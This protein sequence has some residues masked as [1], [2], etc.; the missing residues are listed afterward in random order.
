MESG[1]VEGKEEKEEV[2]VQMGR[3]EGEEEAW[4]GDVAETGRREGRWGEVGRHCA[5]CLSFLLTCFLQDSCFN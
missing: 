3:R 5:T 1:R 4:I 2:V